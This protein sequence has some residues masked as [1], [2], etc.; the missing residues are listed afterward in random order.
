MPLYS[1]PYFSLRFAL[2]P[3][4][5]SLSGSVSAKAEPP[6]VMYNGCLAVPAW[7]E[8]SEVLVVSEIDSQS[9]LLCL[10][11]LFTFQAL[12]FAGDLCVHHF[13]PC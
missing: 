6:V 4:T 1:A 3:W 7:E 10:I 9:V 2:C 8:G 13:A 12:N 11:L 5:E